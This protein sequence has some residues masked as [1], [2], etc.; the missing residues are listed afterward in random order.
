MASAGRAARN[1]PQSVWQ[2]TDPVQVVLM[3]VAALAIA[4]LMGLDVLFRLM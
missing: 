4:T 1:K 2:R 3:V